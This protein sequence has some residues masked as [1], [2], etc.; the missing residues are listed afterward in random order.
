MVFVE[1]QTNITADDMEDR[2][3]PAHSANEDCSAFET[4][5]AVPH[6]PAVPEFAALSHQCFLL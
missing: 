3:S 4:A 5:E 6:S 1:K 2:A